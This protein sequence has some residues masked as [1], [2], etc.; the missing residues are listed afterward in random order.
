[1]VIESAKDIL[2]CLFL[3]K[4]AK[5]LSIVK[6]TRKPTNVCKSSLQEKIL[7]R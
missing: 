7:G 5:I 6:N 4:T 1:M 2:R 3:Q